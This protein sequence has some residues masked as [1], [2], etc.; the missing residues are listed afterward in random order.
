MLGHILDLS[1]CD[2]IT[3]VSMLGNVHKLNVY[4]CA[5]IKNISM[6]RNIHMLD[7][8]FYNHKYMLKC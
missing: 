2:K 3:D 8:C 4:Y 6:L 5:N 1:Y 7:L